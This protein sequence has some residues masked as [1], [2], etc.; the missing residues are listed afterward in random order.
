MLMPLIDPPNTQ[1]RFIQIG[2]IVSRQQPGLWDSAE[3]RRGCLRLAR[4]YAVDADD[5]DDITQEALLRAWRYRSSLR[6]GEQF[7]GWL[8]RIVHNEA[9]R[10]HARAVP[11]PVAEIRESAEVR[12]EAALI[13]RLDLQSA[14]ANLTPAEREMVCLRYLADLTQPAI[15]RAL[16]LP[17]GTVKVRLHRARAKLHRALREP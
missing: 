7:W 13:E 3:L 5:A 4:R 8:A 9:A 15:A 6:A 14:V 1:D 2:N 11:E 17:E 10:I 12:D 16:D